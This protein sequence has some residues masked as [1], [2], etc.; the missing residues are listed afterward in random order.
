MRILLFI[1]AAVASSSGSGCS[2]QQFY[3]SG[4]AWQRS[5]CNKIVDVQDRQRCLSKANTS[6]DNYQRQAEE[7]KGTK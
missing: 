2:S 7:A 4:Q 3:A 5:E 1:A 6:Y